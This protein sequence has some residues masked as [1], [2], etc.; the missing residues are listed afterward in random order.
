VAIAA[1]T[2]LGP[3]EVIGSLGAG[4]MG[5]VYKARDTR[6]DRIVAIKILPSADPERR[7]RFERE[8][9]AIAALSHPHI[10]TLHDIGHQLLPGDSEPTDFLVIE[11][12]EG[13]TL[14]ERVAAGPFETETLVELGIQIA[15]ALDAA[16]TAN[17]IHRDIKPANI[18]IT[19][20]RH[21]KILDFGVAKLD[22]ASGA[23]DVALTRMATASIADRLTTPGTTLGT[24]AYM[25]PEQAR[26]EELD[27]RTDLFSFGLVLY[28]M[29]TGRA[30]FQ[31]RTAAIIFDEI[32]NRPPLPARVLNPA[33]PSSIDQI[34]QKSLQKDRALR[35]QSAADVRAAFE[36]V[37]KAPAETAATPQP[38]VAPPQTATAA[39]APPAQAPVFTSLKSEPVSRMP[40]FMPPAAAEGLHKALDA[41]LGSA[42]LATRTAGH[43]ARQ[44]ARRVASDRSRSVSALR[45]LA[46]AGVDCR[47]SFL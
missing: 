3:Y 43:V 21:A 32:L 18:F 30:A 14:A 27:P 22:S 41:A 23:D 19:R 31:G 20:R 34:I 9:R 2:R 37:K 5:E 8:A 44:A 47:S 36:A 10:C 16:H 11:Y 28:E 29:A 38:P 26:G 7:Q 39:A 42:E 15:D 46:Q 13:E 33:L 17:V 1:G 6:L 24:V 25:S 45:G 4:G 12:L 40:P 35:F